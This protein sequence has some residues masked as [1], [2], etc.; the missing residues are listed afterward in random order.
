MRYTLFFLIIFLLTSPL[1][2]IDEESYVGFVAD[3][4][5][6]MHTLKNNHEGIEIWADQINDKYPNFL[7]EDL[8]TFETSLSQ[9][10]TLKNKIYKKIL[11][12]IRAQ[13]YKAT[14]VETADGTTI[15]EIK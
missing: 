13:G 5:I 3:S 14:L 8:D 10:P 6:A 9:N 4:T 7:I 15:V 1:W 11:K 12:N 2:A